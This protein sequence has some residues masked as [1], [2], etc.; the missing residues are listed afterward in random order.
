[1]PTIS[2]RLPPDLHDVARVAA[3][4]KR[5]SLTAYLLAQIRAG[6]L[7]DGLEDRAVAAALDRVVT[8][9]PDRSR[10]AGS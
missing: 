3:A 10:H 1:M 5:Q 9:G 6:V 8:V 2:L 4:S 7:R